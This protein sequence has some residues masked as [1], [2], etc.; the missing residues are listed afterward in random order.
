MVNK[1]NKHTSPLRFGVG[2]L[3]SKK[4]LQFKRFGTMIEIVKL[5]PIPIRVFLLII[6]P[7]VNYY[8]TPKH[9]YF[10][11]AFCRCI[12]AL[13]NIVLFIVNRKMI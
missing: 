13:P 4:L 1:L 3:K 11:N 9:S 8:N 7:H 6:P 12:K 5:Y 10:V 2:F